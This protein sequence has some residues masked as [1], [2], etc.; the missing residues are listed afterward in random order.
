MTHSGRLLG[1]GAIVEVLL[2]AAV[3][4]LLWSR[5]LNYLRSK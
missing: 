2:T 4:K 5:A 1:V 3:S